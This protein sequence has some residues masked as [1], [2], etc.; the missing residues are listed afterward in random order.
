LV[1]NAVDFEEALNVAKDMGS[2]VL[3]F[4]ARRV[5]SSKATTATVTAAAR[6]RITSTDIQ[7]QMMKMQVQN[8]ISPIG[9]NDQFSP[10]YLRMLHAGVPKDAVLQ[11]MKLDDAGHY[12][13]RPVGFNNPP[14]PSNKGCLNK[15]ARIMASCIPEVTQK[16]NVYDDLDPVYR[17]MLQFGVPWDAVVQRM[18]RDGYERPTPSV[19]VMKNRSLV[20]AQLSKSITSKVELVAPPHITA[21]AAAAASPRRGRGALNVAIHEGCKLRKTSTNLRTRPVVV[22]TNETTTNE[23]TLPRFSHPSSNVQH[24]TSSARNETLKSI[25]SQA[26]KPLRHVTPTPSQ[27]RKQVSFSNDVVVA[28]VVEESTVMPSSS[29]AVAVPFPSPVASP[30]PVDSQ[31]ERNLALMEA[32]GFLDR[33]QNVALLARFNGR[34]E[35]AVCHV[36][37][38]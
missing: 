27:T 7:N 23:T 37:N 26:K 9:S 15:S 4:N 30:P 3:K 36:L 17:K 10:K 38:M 21:Q 11:R 6:M 5:Q 28:R 33:S 1:T 12:M 8:Q 25:V 2:K 13:S 18:K 29:V 20:H 32:M 31:M 34:V 16:K 24:A 14:P 35:S 19:S 22:I